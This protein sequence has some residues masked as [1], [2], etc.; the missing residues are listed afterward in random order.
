MSRFNIG[1]VAAMFAA[2]LGAMINAASAAQD[3]NQLYAPVSHEKRIAQGRNTPTANFSSPP[4]GELPILFNDRYIYPTPNT[5]SHGRLL[6]ALVQG[7]T[8]LVPLRSLFEQLGG[9]VSYD[10][11][12]KTVDVSKPGSDIKVTVGKSEVEVNG[13]TRPLDVPPE[14]Y[15]GAV[16][17]PVRV[18]CES[19]GAYVEWTKTHLTN[20]VLSKGIGLYAQPVPDRHIIVVRYVGG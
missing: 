20:H 5:L 6:S 16:V 15:Q 13:K 3:D 8:V 4:S 12:D 19:L 2:A 11:A 9:T 1:A 10:S 17:V 14:I 18:I 7:T